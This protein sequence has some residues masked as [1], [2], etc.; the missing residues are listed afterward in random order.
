M[1]LLLILVLLSYQGLLKGQILMS[2]YSSKMVNSNFIIEYHSLPDRNFKEFIYLVQFDT[3]IPRLEMHFANRRDLDYFNN[4]VLCFLSECH[5][6]RQPLLFPGSRKIL[7]DEE[8][9]AYVYEDSKSVLFSR[10]SFVQFAR[11]IQNSTKR[12]RVRVSQ[13]WQRLKVYFS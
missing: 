7:Y 5:R 13:G 3:L 8:R 6:D 9:R 10:K 2:T 12:S 11:E 4:Y 1:R